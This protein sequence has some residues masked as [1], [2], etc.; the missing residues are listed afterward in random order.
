MRCLMRCRSRPILLL[1]EGA[2]DPDQGEFVLGG[3]K[4]I[5]FDVP[6][7][8]AARARAVENSR[9]DVQGLRRDME[10]PGDLLE[11]VCG[12]FTQPALDLAQIRIGNP[13]ELGKTSQGEP[14]HVALLADELPE[15]TPAINRVSCHP[16]SVLGLGSL[17][18]TVAGRDLAAV[19]VSQPLRDVGAYR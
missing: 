13:G 1:P 4:R 7:Q 12:R 5:C 17:L 16:R 2:V 9:L 3:E 8:I 6:D 14:R 19:Q 10:R 11:D 15:V 18:T